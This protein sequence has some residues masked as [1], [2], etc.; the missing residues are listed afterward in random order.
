M[1][2]GLMAALVLLLLS[3]SA[4]IGAVLVS[5]RSRMEL[6]HRVKLIAAAP[7]PRTTDA[8]GMSLK[9]RLGRFDARLQRVFAAGVDHVWAMKASAP[10]LI[11]ISIA[12]GIAAWV[13]LRDA[14]TLSFWIA[15][16]AAAFSAFIVPRL[17]LLRQQRKT[18]R[19][20]LDLFPDA[21]DAIVRM[22][23]AGLPITSAI[24]AVSTEASPPVN[25][26]FAMIAD[27][28]AIGV[29]VEEALDARSR[30]IG[31]ADFRFFTVAVV[32]QHATG[33]NLAAT[34]E[35]LSDI[36]RKRRAVRLKAN[37]ATAEIRVSAYV[38]GSLPFLVVGTLMIIQPG[39]LTPL[40]VDPRGQ[41]ILAMAAGGM[42]LAAISMRQMMRSV[43]SL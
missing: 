32:M 38:L 23:R 5:R 35:V 34:L 42:L 11:L 24:R 2:Y 33:G 28:L 40:F 15:G 14:L 30:H 22:L 29:P 37:A 10:S 8:V 41:L 20:F 27:Q 6:E 21:V 16:P 25:A 13:V 18:E 39:Y 1:V 7:E 17:V 19:Q 26:V 12:A 4:L 31:L 9:T 3:G 36:I 43:T